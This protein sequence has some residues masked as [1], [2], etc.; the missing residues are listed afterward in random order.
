MDQLIISGE[1]NFNY[2]PSTN[3]IQTGFSSLMILNNTV[4]ID[5]TNQRVGINTTVPTV[6]LDING[7]LAKTAGS[8]DIVHPDPMKAS[9][10]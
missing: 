7:T 8:F 2:W 5:N 6:A 1:G 9:E 3:F 4:Y 10:G